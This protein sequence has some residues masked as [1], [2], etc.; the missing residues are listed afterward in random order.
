MCRWIAAL[1]VLG[2]V[3]AAEAKTYA[4]AIYVG[5]CQTVQGSAPLGLWGLWPTDAVAAAGWPPSWW[6][7]AAAMA[8]PSSTCPRQPGCRPRW[9]GRMVPAL[10]PN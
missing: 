1:L 3:R 4:K 6:S 7:S 9:R 2:A 8:L 5:G 10:T